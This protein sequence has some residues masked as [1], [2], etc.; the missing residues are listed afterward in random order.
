MTVR[1]GERSRRVRPGPQ[2]ASYGARDPNRSGRR[3]NQT[4]VDLT[5]CLA[6]DETFQLICRRISCNGRLS[7][8]YC[9]VSCKSRFR[10][11]TAY[12]CCIA[13]GSHRRQFGGAFDGLR[14]SC[15]VQHLACGDTPFCSSCTSSAVHPCWR[16]FYET[17]SQVSAPHTRCTLSSLP[18]QHFSQSV[19]C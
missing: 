12:N 2:S 5:A 17:E 14:T 13:S 16:S 19:C 1:N 18:L 15:D 10:P 3:S 8:R 7:R 9:R 11:S 6:A 4:I